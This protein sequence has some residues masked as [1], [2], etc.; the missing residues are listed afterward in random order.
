MRGWLKVTQR[1]QKNWSSN[2][3]H[4]LP[5]LHPL[6]KEIE[7]QVGYCQGHRAELAKNLNLLT[8]RLV[9]HVSPRFPLLEKYSPRGLQICSFSSQVIQKMFPFRVDNKEFA[10]FSEMNLEPH[11]RET[12]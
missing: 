3:L 4:L 1:K 5:F 8:S 9:L 10:L 6:C 7:P 12:Q 11:D 2:Q